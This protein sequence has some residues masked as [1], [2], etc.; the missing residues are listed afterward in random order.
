[1]SRFADEVATHE[2]RFLADWLGV[3]MRQRYID[4][5]MFGDVLQAPLLGDV[6]EWQT[7]ARAIEGAKSRLAP[8]PPDGLRGPARVGL[9]A[10]RACTR[11]AARIRG[12]RPAARARRPVVPA[13]VPEIRWQGEGALPFD[14]W[15]PR[16]DGPGTPWEEWLDVPK[17]LDLLAPARFEVVLYTEL[18]DQN[19]NSAVS[20]LL[21]KP[22]PVALHRTSG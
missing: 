21:I 12:A 7:L 6:Y 19:F 4:A 18:H 20:T 15:G 9:A 22:A 16:T 10:Q 13:R 2:P 5:Q 8:D 1:V 17:L 3:T 14:E 11:D